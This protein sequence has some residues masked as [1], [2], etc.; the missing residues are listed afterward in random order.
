MNLK[1]LLTNFNP[2]KKEYKDSKEFKDSKVEEPEVSEAPESIEVPEVKA[3][4]TFGPQGKGGA[5]KLGENEKQIIVSL[6]ANG[7]TPTEIQDRTRTEFNFE[8]S[9]QQIYVYSRA[10]KWQPLIRKIRQETYNDI[11]SVAGS[12]KKVRLE[13]GEKIYDKAMGS[14]KYDLAL[15]AVDNQ[16]REMEGDGAVNVTLNQFNNFSDEELVVKQREALEKVKR[17]TNRGITI[18]QPAD[19]TEAVKA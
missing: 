1:Q 6:F 7:L 9:V 5:W 3:K 17:L 11:S 13:R 8:V 16:R 12:H 2:F 14:R 4:R 15:K 18:E 10:E 19:K